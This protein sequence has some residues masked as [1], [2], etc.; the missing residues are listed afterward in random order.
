MS[1]RNKL[2]GAYFNGALLIAAAFGAAAQSWGVFVVSL[3][4][5][6]F[7]MFLAGDIRSSRQKRR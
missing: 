6:L 1:A 5:I 7:A 4:G 2:N 3:A